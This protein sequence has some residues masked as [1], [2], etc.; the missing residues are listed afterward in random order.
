MTRSHLN[1]HVV[2]IAEGIL[3]LGLFWFVRLDQLGKDCSTEFS[4][5]EFD[6]VLNL[7]MGCTLILW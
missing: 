3:S 4:A 6:F 1:F 5:C 7:K 2:S